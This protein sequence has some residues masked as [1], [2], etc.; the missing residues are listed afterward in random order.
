M[1][2]IDDLEELK[3]IC[4]GAMVI[5]E[6]GQTFYCLPS[7]KLPDGCTIREC[8]ALLCVSQHGSYSTRLFLAQ[9]PGRGANPSTHCI[10]GRTWHTWSWNNVPG[11]LRPAQILAEH[12]RGLQ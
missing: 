5:R 10:V 12:L 4:E 2:R 3:L 8:E 6:G 9:P 1:A 7:L 11:G